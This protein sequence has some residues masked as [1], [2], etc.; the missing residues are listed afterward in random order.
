MP[1]PDEPLVVLVDEV[2][3]DK[4]EDVGEEQVDRKVGISVVEELEP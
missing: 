1:S 2:K 3:G 4:S